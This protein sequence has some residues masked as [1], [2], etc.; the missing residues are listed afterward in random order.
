M[1]T[2]LKQSDYIKDV[3]QLYDTHYQIK[4]INLLST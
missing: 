2:L 1:T 4:I 3:T